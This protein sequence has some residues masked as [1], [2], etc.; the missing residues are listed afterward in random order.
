[1][2]E[3]LQCMNCGHT[4]DSHQYLGEEDTEG[5]RDLKRTEDADEEVDTEALK[6]IDVDSIQFLLNAYIDLVLVNLMK[7]SI[8]GD[9][10]ESSLR[11]AGEM[12]IMMKL[13]NKSQPVPPNKHKQLKVCFTQR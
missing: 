1:M 3:D 7:Q 13:L 9:T 10:K 6:E 5:D 12:I 8:Q 2:F 4:P 11:R